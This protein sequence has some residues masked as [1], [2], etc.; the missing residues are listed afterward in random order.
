M[1][2]LILG[3]ITILLAITGH[4]ASTTISSLPILRTPSTNTYFEIS[5]MSASPMS[6]KLWLIDLANAVATNS[7]ILKLNS[8]DT[9]ILGT[10]LVWNPATL[11]LRLAGATPSI[12]LWNSSGTAD[13]RRF[14][15]DNAFDQ[16]RVEW[17]D[18]AGGTSLLLATY[19]ADGNF[20]P[21]SLSLSGQTNRLTM[22][23]NQLLLDGSPIIG[24]SN[25][26]V[27]NFY[28]TNF[29]VQNGNHNNMI[30]S[31]SFKLI[32]AGPSKILR[33]DSNTNVVAAVIGT[34][35]AFDGTNLTT[36]GSS[37][38]ASVWIPNTALTYS[39]GTNI[40]MDASGGTNFTVAVTN[41]IFMADPTNPPGSTSTNTSWTMTFKMDGTGG[42]AVTWTNKFKGIQF[43]PLTNANAVSMVTI[44][45]SSFTNGQYYLDYGITGLQ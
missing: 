35:L 33:T 3:L 25:A 8:F 14:I 42:Y 6:R 36:T 30:V 1:N 34:G 27:N 29:Y 19:S 18:D 13:F 15:F 21:I 26:P 7:S 17:S 2:K 9:N 38:G 44:T 12:E 28:A 23:N 41:T 32:P 11:R 40:T 39:G 37:S 43:Q 31:N 24:T 45:T 20:S 10:N 22:A 5:D 16:L 4:A